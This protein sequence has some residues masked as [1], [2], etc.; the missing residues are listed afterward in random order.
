MALLILTSIPSEAQSSLFKPFTSLRVIKTEHFDI[1]FPQESEPSARLLASYADQVYE[2][3][4][5]LLG[6]E[7]PFRIPVTL[8]PH[9]DQINGYYSWLPLPHIVLFDTPMDLEWTNFANNL[10]SLFLHELTHAVSMNTR[11]PVQR[12]FHRIFGNLFT[13][14]WYNAPYFMAEGVTVSFESL[15]GFGRVNDPLTKQKLRQALYEGKFLTPFQASGVYDIPG[16][17][18]IYYEYGGLFSAWLQRTYG[19]EKYAELWQ[20]MGRDYYYSFFVYRADFYGIFR[21]LYDIE[22]LEAWRTF[23]VSMALNGLEENPGELLPKKYRLFSEKKSFISALAVGGSDLYFFNSSESK[24]RVYDTGTGKTRTLNTGSS[25]Y[26]YDIDVSAD[27]TLLLISGYRY[28]GNRA[29]TAV[30]EHRANS[31]LRTSRSFQ[32]LYKARYFR[33]GVI[34]LSSELHNTCIAYEDFNG[35]R[36]ILFRGNEGLVFSGP[37]AVDNER[38]VFVAARNGIRELWLYNYVS[39]ELFRVEDS[40]NQG[41]GNEHRLYMRDLSVS[42]GKLFFSHNADDRMYKLARIDLETMQAVYSDR[43]FSGGVFNPVAIDD[44]IYYTGNFFSGDSLLR[45]PESTGSLS[46]KQSNLE[47][48]KLDVNNFDVISMTDTAPNAASDAPYDLPLSISPLPS[49]PYFGLRYMN[50]LQLWFP[51]PLIRIGDSAANDFGISLDGGGFITMMADPAERNLVMLWALADIRYWMASIPQ[52]LWQNTFLGFPVQAAFS[53]T[54]TK[55]GNFLYRSTNASLAGSLL[56]TTGRWAHIFSPG[57]A[58]TRI[59]DDDGTDSAYYWKETGSYFSVYANYTLSNL[60]Q[61]SNELFGTGLELFVGGGSITNV[62]KP[63]IVGGGRTSVET[64]FPVRLTLFG[65]Y[66]GMGMDLHGVS[67]IYGSGQLARDY[68]L[69]EYPHPA[70]LDINWLAGGEISVGLF[71]LEIQKNISHLYFNRFF[72]TLSVRN[73]FYDSKGHPNADGIEIND[74]RLIQSLRLKLAMKVTLLPFIKTPVSIEP[75]IW[76]AWKF[77]NTITGKRNLLSYGGGAADS[78]GLL[79]SLFLTA[80]FKISF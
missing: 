76:G 41:S 77:S 72:G 44:A 50:P 22:F 2:H 34:G 52:I 25:Y 40:S 5:S 7:V 12:F 78:L 80:G 23:G 68:T 36:E 19:M 1:I 9:T 67:R 59:A 27:G 33:D 49:K 18:G 63:R 71:S 30:T 64:M 29:V 51:M 73:V 16:Q 8:T 57:S 43:D 54:V 38:I 37:Q 14:A 20:A 11:S 47:M 70:G 66:D 15:T 4:S 45:F 13:P 74:L 55:S 35:N 28:I 53:D 61:R 79:N 6:I 26:P 42:D 56:W 17:E 75:Y 65:I 48:V 69:T 39:R 21:R 58:Y 46:G 32:E 62:F 31:G 60:R 10:E 24:I 3:V